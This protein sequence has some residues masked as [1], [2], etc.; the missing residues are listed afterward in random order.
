[1]HTYMHYNLHY[2]ALHCIPFIALLHTALRRCVQKFIKT[3]QQTQKPKQTKQPSGAP[4]SPGPA[5]LSAPPSSQRSGA[6]ASRGCPRRGAE[7]GRLLGSRGAPLWAQRWQVSGGETHCIKGP[8]VKAS[9]SGR[10]KAVA[11]KVIWS[12]RRSGHVRG[13][14]CYQGRPSKQASG[15]T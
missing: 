4:C 9:A 13:V 8:E 11:Q 14:P 15:V 12:I 7:T 5:R 10:S 6:T 3:S 2:I 1:M